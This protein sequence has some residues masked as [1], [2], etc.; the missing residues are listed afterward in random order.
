MQSV[1]LLV[2]LGHIQAVS[3]CCNCIQTVSEATGEQFAGAL[4]LRIRQ[5][6]NVTVRDRLQ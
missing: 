4:Y 6:V 3:S 2:L 1:K 5:H